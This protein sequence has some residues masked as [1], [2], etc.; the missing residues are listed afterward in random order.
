MVSAPDSQLD[1]LDL[2]LEREKAKRHTLRKEGRLRRIPDIHII[3]GKRYVGSAPETTT[4][5][6]QN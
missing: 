6:P 1:A 4:H 5:Q 2:M 3:G